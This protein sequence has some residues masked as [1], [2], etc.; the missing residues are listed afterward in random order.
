MNFEYLMK[1]NAHF[2]VFMIPQELK[3]AAI[4]GTNEYSHIDKANGVHGGN[5]LCSPV[6][7][8][9]TAPNTLPLYNLFFLPSCGRGILMRLG[10]QNEM[11][12]LA[13][14]GDA[15]GRKVCGF[16]LA[17]YLGLAPRRQTPRANGKP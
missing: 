13:R 16:P 10:F 5:G 14:L 7:I 17:I 1:S 9:R 3:I 6:K 4:R 8:V 15:S 11:D 12:S 2:P